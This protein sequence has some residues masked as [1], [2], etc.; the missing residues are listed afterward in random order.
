MPTPARTSLE[1]IVAAGRQALAG[2]GLEA[3]T[4]QHVARIVGVRAPSLYKRVRD[5]SDLVRLVVEDVLR[6]LTGTLEAAATTGD[7][8]LD[9]RAV[10]QS[11]RAFARSQPNAFGL[12]F[13]PLP[14]ESVPNLELVERASGP[15]L[16]LVEAI[17]GREDAL[18]AARTVTAWATGFVRMELA[19]AFQLGGDV[20]EAFEYG[21]N[22]LVFAL[23]AP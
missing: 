8:A 15:L 11:F 7:P 6:E 22:S 13:S 19:G 23:S 20:D 2:G 1:A 3:L 16:R 14:G 21:I 4:M 5:R 12:L 9:L 18:A 17:V 10:A